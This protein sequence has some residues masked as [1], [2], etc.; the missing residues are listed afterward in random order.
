MP[1]PPGAGDSVDWDAV[2]ASWGTR[3]PGDYKEFMAAYGEGVI[4]D[5]LSLMA[6]E[7]HVDPGGESS[8]MGM[9]Q[10]SANAEDVWR[11]SGPGAAETPRL[12]AW[13]ADS[14]ADFLCWLATDAD[15]DKWPV[16]VWGRGDARWT[17]YPCGMVEFLLRL[18]RAEFDE[19]PLGA[20]SLWGVGS[21]RFLHRQEEQR[22]R[23][24]GISPWTGEPDPYAGMFG[25]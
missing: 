20:V 6:P 13:G 21:A 10:E 14:S 9:Q 23:M 8:Y 12:I 24:A 7:T 5:Y 19:C 15:P 11:A 17:E 18:F 2:E 25:D 16:V 4:D 22:L 1:S 3:F